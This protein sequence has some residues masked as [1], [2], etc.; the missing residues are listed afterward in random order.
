MLNQVRHQL[1]RRLP[2]PTLFGLRRLAARLQPEEPELALVRMLAC[3]DRAF[4]D[5]GANTGM[6]VAAALGRY[7]RIYAAEP[8]PELAAYLRSSLGT[9]ATVFELALSDRAGGLPLYLP[10]HDARVVAS[11]ASLEAD[12]NPGFGQTC[13]QVP[14]KRLDEPRP[15]PAGTGQDRCRGPRARRDRGWPHAPR[16]RSASPDRRDRR[17]TSSRAVR[18]NRRVHRGARL[19]RLLSRRRP[20]ASAGGHLH[21]RSSAPGTPET[22]GRIT[23]A[24]RSVCQQLPLSAR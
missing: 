10:I 16:P 13:V 12:A 23:R 4:L 1:V 8:Y 15:P 3:S 17:A 18:R 20:A 19:R 24:Q 11:R 6:Y 22:C 7:A 2:A 5:V 9:R 14:V 21:R